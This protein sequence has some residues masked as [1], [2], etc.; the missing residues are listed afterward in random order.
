[1]HKDRSN[2]IRPPARSFIARAVI[3]ALAI[4]AL[5]AT[6]CG[7][8]FPPDLLS[9]R[10]ASLFDLVDGTFDYEASRLAPKTTSRSAGW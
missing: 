8:E 4:V 9:D 5:P 2:G 10:H 6:A 1:M 7:P 3:A